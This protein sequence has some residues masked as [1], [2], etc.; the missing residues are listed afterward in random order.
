MADHNPAAEQEVRAAVAAFN[1][2]AREADGA[3]LD[4]LL[5][6]ELFYGHSNALMEN[7]AVCIEHLLRGRIDFRD[8][9]GSEVQIHGDTAIFHGKTMAHNPKPEGVV[10]VPLDLVQVWVKR[11]GKWQMVARH[12][13]K[14][15]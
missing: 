5:G 6:E 13:T 3:A 12:T 4:G 10:I 14:L 11:G 9:P 15:P 7:K 1:R 8:E 2:A